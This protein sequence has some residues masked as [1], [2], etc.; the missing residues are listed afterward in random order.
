MGVRQGLIQGQRQHA[1][2]AFAA[3][4]TLKMVLHRRRWRWLYCHGLA[5]Q[6]FLY[7]RP[8]P[9]GQTSLRPT[10]AARLGA[11][12]GATRSEGHTSELQTLMRNS[13]AVLCFKKKQHK[14]K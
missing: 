7:L 6:H 11:D 14:T 10:L 9:H 1:G 13:Y 8:D 12:F 2:A 3:G 4:R 5:P